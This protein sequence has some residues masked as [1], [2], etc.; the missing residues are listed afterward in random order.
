MGNEV[1]E[2]GLGHNCY[3]FIILPRIENPNLL[4]PPFNFHILTIYNK[5]FGK[6]E[7]RNN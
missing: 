2:P 4:T 6:P 7:E 3:V 1:K 5:D